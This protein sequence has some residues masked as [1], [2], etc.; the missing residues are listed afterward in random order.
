MLEYLSSGKG[1]FPYEV[2]SRFDSLSARPEDRDFSEISPF[3]LG[4]GMGVSLRKS[5]RVVKSFTRL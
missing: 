2:V 4:F 5:G 1:C 3:T